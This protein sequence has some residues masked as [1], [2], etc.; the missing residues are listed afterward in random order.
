MSVLKEK[1]KKGG[2]RKSKETGDCWTDMGA[3]LSLAGTGKTKRGERKGMKEMM[4]SLQE[5]TGGKTVSR[6]DG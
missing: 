6:G 2:D 5:N 1:K 4:D 3:F